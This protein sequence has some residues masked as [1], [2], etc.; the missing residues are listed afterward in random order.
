VGP[1]AI[2]ETDK[3]KTHNYVPYIEI[4]TKL[5]HKIFVYSLKICWHSVY[6]IPTENPRYNLYEIYMI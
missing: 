2:L 3:E 4:I 6:R 1:E 5:M